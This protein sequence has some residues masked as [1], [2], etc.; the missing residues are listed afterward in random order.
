MGMPLITKTKSIN[1][2]IYSRIYF[3]YSHDLVQDEIFS[4][5]GN[6]EDLQNP[7]CVYRPESAAVKERI[8]MSLWLG[9]FGLI[10]LH[11]QLQGKGD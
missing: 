3:L 7:E 8:H 6:K 1:T 10:N 9:G 11:Q 4:R 5:R 2:F